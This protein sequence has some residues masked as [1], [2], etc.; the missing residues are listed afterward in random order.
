VDI[1][2]SS[3]SVIIS[4]FN[5]IEVMKI[6]LKIERDGEAYYKGALD[7]AKDERM[8][9][10]FKR[11]AEDELKHYGMFKS[12]YDALLREKGID[13]SSVDTEEDLFTYAETGIFNKKAVPNNAKEAVFE[14]ENAEIRSIL[15]YKELLLKT[16]NESAKKALI[17]IAE[18]EQMH[19]NILKSW[20]AAV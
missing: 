17:Q 6:A 20:E 19:Y 12:L 3:D 7:K 4:D 2:V 15:F 10:T 5:E 16:K 14:S 9:R 1:K 18:E 8:K 11:L 13:P